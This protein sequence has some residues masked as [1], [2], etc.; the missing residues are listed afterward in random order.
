MASAM[1]FYLPGGCNVMQALEAFMGQKCYELAYFY[2]LHFLCWI[3]R[4]RGTWMLRRATV[5]RT[6]WA[7]SARSRKLPSS[8]GCG[9]GAAADGGGAS[10]AETDRQAS[11]PPFLKLKVYEL[12]GRDLNA[13]ESK[14][15]SDNMGKLGQVAVVRRMCRCS[16]QWGSKCCCRCRCSRYNCRWRCVGCKGIRCKDRS[17][18]CRQSCI[19]SR[20][21]LKKHEVAVVKSSCAGRDGRRWRGS[22]RI[23]CCRSC[24]S[25]LQRK[26]IN[27]SK[28]KLSSRP[29]A[30][31]VSPVVT[32][33]PRTLSECS[34]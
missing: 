32:K 22:F 13:P 24:C 17:R 25:F 16:C 27:A 7:N 23:R 20:L 15:I 10:A 33:W 21:V 28:P 4:M 31:G 34:M 8:R 26:W 6:T 19:R 1:V 9:G 30:G 2:I 12:N 18:D 5:S 11:H 14:S 3:D 29:V